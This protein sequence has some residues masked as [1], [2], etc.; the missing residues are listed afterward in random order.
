MK[1]ILFTIILLFSMG[2]IWGQESKFSLGINGGIGTEPDNSIVW[3]L[4]SR[5]NITQSFRVAP[6][7]NLSFREVEF[8]TR[9]EDWTNWTGSINLHY[10]FSYKSISAYPIIGIIFTNGKDRIRSYGGGADVYT[11]S[12]KVLRLGGTMGAGLEYNFLNNFY[13][14]GEARYSILHRVWNQ[15]QFMSMEG[16]SKNLNNFGLS[17]G[18]GYKF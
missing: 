1:K 4:V 13:I 15:N 11:Q 7:F 2:S 16:S 12:I 6:E 17:V 10:L 18:V 3:G 5:Y 14:N 9:Q 8:V